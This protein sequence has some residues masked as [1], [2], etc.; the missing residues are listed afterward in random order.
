MRDKLVRLALITFASGFLFYSTSASASLLTWTLNNVTFNDGG[1]SVGSFVYDADTNLFSNFNISVAGGDITLF[2]PFMYSPATS[3]LRPPLDATDLSLTSNDLQRTLF[4]M[5]EQP[6]TNAGGSILV[7]NPA[8]LGGD[9]EFSG[10]SPPFGHRGFTAGTVDAPNAPTIPE[11][12]TL[13]LFGSGILAMLGYVWR[14]RNPF[15]RAAASQHRTRRGFPRRSRSTLLWH[16]RACGVS[17][18]GSPS[19]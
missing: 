4:M 6:L 10:T 1:T 15:R 8:G 14:R 12:S 18:R 7:Q 17:L 11:P 9:A 5:F 3:F 13:T 16:G 2:P 19:L